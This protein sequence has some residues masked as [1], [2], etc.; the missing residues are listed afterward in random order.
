M[1]ERKAFCRTEFIAPVQSK[2]LR[3]RAFQAYAADGRVHL[4][5][6]EIG[7]RIIKQCVRFLTSPEDHAVDVLSLFFMALVMAH[8]AIVLPDKHQALLADAH[9]DAVEKTHLDRF[10][11]YARHEQS[12]EDRFLRALDNKVIKEE[13]TSVTSTGGSI[14]KMMQ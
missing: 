7:D 8:P 11:G 9:I 2:A 13:G 3:A 10:E 12:L 1:Q 4:P 14:I 5:L 6:G